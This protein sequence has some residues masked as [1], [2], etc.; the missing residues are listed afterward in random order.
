MRAENEKYRQ[1]LIKKVD[2]SAGYSFVIEFNPKRAKFYLQIFNV[3]WNILKS[4]FNW[5]K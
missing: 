5:E 2:K 4:R 1:I 3:E